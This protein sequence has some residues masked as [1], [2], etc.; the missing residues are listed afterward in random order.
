MADNLIQWIAPVRE[1]RIE[2]EKHPARV[3]EILDAGSKHARVE[4][5]QTMERVREA[6]F[7]WKRKRSEIHAGFTEVHDTHG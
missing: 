5:Q 1:R 3:L 4:A 6:V 2:Y 7:G